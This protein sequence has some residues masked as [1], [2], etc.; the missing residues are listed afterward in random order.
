M[1]KLF[2]LLNQSIYDT[3]WD[4]PTTTIYCSFPRQEHQFSSEDTATIDFL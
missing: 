1:Y 3:I 2:V 4:I